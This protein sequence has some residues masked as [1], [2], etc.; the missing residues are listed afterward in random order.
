MSF[1]LSFFVS[2]KKNW[3]NAATREKANSLIARFF[4]F[5][6]IL[7]LVNTHYQ[8]LDFYYYFSIVRALQNSKNSSHLLFTKSLLKV[9]ND[10]AMTARSCCFTFLN[11]NFELTSVHYCYIVW[12][13][14][15][16][17]KNLPKVNG[18]EIVVVSPVT[19]L[20]S[21]LQNLKRI[22]AYCSQL[23]INCLAILLF[24]ETCSK[25]PFQTV[26]QYC[27][28]CD[29]VLFTCFENASFF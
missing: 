1:C 16:H 7:S 9:C 24:T 3:S 2:Q 8:R 14:S 6:K 25:Q 4:I 28:Y 20:G 5:M 12:S 23:Y 17:A 18:R 22:L 15:S 19:A 26:A 27:L 13:G 10:Q 29:T 11:T 21:F